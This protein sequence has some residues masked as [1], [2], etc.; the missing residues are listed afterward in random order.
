M[1]DAA[2]IDF[3]PGHGDVA[4]VK[5]VEDFRAYLLDLRRL[6]TEGRKAGLKDDALAQA[7]RRSCGR[8]TPTGRSAT[9]PPR[10]RSLHG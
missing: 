9:A 4:D 1:P 7:S 10:P 3:V 2:Q 6:V 8:F 5:D